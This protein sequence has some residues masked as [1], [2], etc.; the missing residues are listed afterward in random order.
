MRGILPTSWLSVGLVLSACGGSV[1]EPD[2][3]TSEGGGGAGGGGPGSFEACPAAE[4]FKARIEL[5]GALAHEDCEF[6]SGDQA[7]LITEG[8]LT[9]S[10]PGSFDID[11]C[12]KNCESPMVYH[13]TLDTAG[14]PIAIPDGTYV[15]MRFSQADSVYQCGYALSI[16]NIPTFDGGQ[17][18]TE[19]GTAL[20]LHAEV[21]GTSDEAPVE[22]DLSEDQVCG[23]DPSHMEWPYGLD[24][25][26]KESLDPSKTIQIPMGETVTWSPGTAALPGSYLAKNLASLVTSVETWD[27]GFVVARKGA[28]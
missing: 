1:P 18:P 15:E 2:G 5:N 4:H 27:I 17:N 10:G 21:F 14:V 20:W 19:D 26:L 28:E 7:K 9:S 3:T 6:H 22:H 12:P 24:L 25:I 8:I 23:G 11:S 13:V 16:R